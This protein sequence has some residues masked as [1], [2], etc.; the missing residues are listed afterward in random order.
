MLLSDGNHCGA[1]LIIEAGH[2]S[3]SAESQTC[4]KLR[5]QPTVWR[6]I[7]MLIFNC[8]PF[9]S[10][11][12]LSFSIVASNMSREFSLSHTIFAR[13]SWFSSLC[14]Q[15]LAKNRRVVIRLNVGCAITQMNCCIFVRF[16][17]AMMKL[18]TESEMTAG[19]IQS[20]SSQVQ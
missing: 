8:I 4:S 18:H 3:Y 16:G 12:C 17:K 7:L 11:V 14:P 20:L 10:L 13:H 1:T 2:W 6:W 15:E 9:E 19:T 5:A